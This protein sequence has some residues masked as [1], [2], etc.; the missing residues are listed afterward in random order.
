MLRDDAKPV[1]SSLLPLVREGR[2]LDLASGGDFG[3]E[4]AEANVPGTMS[5]IAPVAC[6][7]IAGESVEVVPT[8]RYC[9]PCRLQH[10][11]H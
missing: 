6:P 1:A 3:Q 7:E 2:V 8:T 4:C 9:R 5:P 10:R 11:F